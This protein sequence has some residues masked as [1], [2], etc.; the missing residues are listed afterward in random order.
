MGSTHQTRA[1]RQPG[2]FQQSRAGGAV[3]QWSV[4]ARPNRWVLRAA[5]DRPAGSGQTGGVEWHRSRARLTRTG[6]AS[7]V[8]EG[9]VGAGSAGSPA[10]PAGQGLAGSYLSFAR[11]GKRQGRWCRR[12]GRWRRRGREGSAGWRVGPTASGGLSEPRRAGRGTGGTGGAGVAGL[13]VGRAVTAGRAVT[14]GS[15]ATAGPGGAAGSGGTG[16]GAQ[17]ARAGPEEPAA[18]ATSR[19]R[20]ELAGPA[21]RRDQ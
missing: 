12:H 15:P 19:S 16:A 4:S 3:M 2:R 6:P 11:G 17:V 13:P 20:A 8:P 7:G 14:Q 18:P 10:V 9:P 5:P 1:R 21:D